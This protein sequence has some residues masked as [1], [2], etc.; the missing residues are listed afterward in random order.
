MEGPGQLL[1]GLGEV[2]LGESDPVGDGGGVAPPGLVDGVGLDAA[3]LG[4]EARHFYSLRHFIDLME[5]KRDVSNFHSFS[6]GIFGERLLDF[7][8][9]LQ[10]N[11][12]MQQLCVTWAAISFSLLSFSMKNLH[13]IS[14]RICSATWWLV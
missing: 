13:F 4:A 2:L 8:N 3:L 9:F 6:K 7:E 1:P 12:K 10:E 5:T 11:I 14:S